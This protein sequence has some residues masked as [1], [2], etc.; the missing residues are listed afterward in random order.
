MLIY[1][2][3][4]N[5]SPAGGSSSETVPAHRHK[6]QGIITITETVKIHTCNRNDVCYLLRAK[7][8]F[9]TLFRKLLSFRRLQ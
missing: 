3:G 7:R 6:Q 2:L 9:H 8:R 4:M 5:N 1:H